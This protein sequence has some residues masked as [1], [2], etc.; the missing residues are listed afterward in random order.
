MKKR[1]EIQIRDPFVLKANNQYYL[2]GSTDVN[3]WG[4]QT[5]KGFDVY[6]GHN[7][8]EWDGPFPAFYPN[9]LYWGKDNF[10]APE[11]HFYQGT[12]YMF[13]TF[14][15]QDMM[16][17][18]AILKSQ[19]AEGPFLPWSEGPV[20]PKEWMSLD[21]TFYMDLGGKPWIVFCHEWVQVTV[22]T[23]CALRLAEDLKSTVGEPIELLKSTDAPW[24]VTGHSKEHNMTGYVT[25]GPNIHR[26]TNGELIMIWSCLGNK[27]YTLG[28][29]LSSNKE[30]SGPW[31]QETIPLFEEDGGHGMIFRQYSGE[32]M[33]AIHQPNDS[34]NERARFV[35]LD[36]TQYGFKTGSV[37]MEDL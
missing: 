27:G 25:D 37:T 35:T 6:I 17:G 1:E 36:E 7:L 34:P 18:T 24:S 20:T 26:L 11:V 8:D 23:I 21:G 9:D 4:K 2:Y 13:A 31:R 28:Y 30:I 29:A 12:Y 14:R 10:W 5:S 32:L 19:N 3:I 22:G 33:L 16:R 15:G